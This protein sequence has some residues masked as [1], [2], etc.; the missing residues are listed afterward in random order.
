VGTSSRRRLSPAVQQFS[1]LVKAGGRVEPLGRT[2]KKNHPVQI[3]RK[4]PSCMTT[5]VHQKKTQHYISDRKHLSRSFLLARAPDPWSA[6]GAQ[7]GV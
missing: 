2:P 5:S 6:F 7:F 3:V 1:Y 4:M